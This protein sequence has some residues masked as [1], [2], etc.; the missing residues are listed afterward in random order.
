MQPIVFEKNLRSKSGVFGLL[1]IPK[2]KQLIQDMEPQFQ[3]LEQLHVD[4]ENAD[5]KY[6]DLIEELKNEAIQQ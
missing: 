1:K 6:N 2:N 3:E 5:K 4:V